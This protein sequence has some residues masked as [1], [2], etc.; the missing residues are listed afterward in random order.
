M[1]TKDTDIQ[2]LLDTAFKTLD[3]IP[4]TRIHS[5]VCAAYTKD[6]T[7]ITSFNVKHYTGAPC[8]EQA[9]LGAACAQGYLPKDLTCLVAVSETRRIVINPC[10]KCRQMLQDICEHIKIV[11]RDSEGKLSVVGIQELL[12]FPYHVRTGEELV[13]PIMSVNEP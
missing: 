4:P 3:K 10:G 5:V 7:I 8:A 11:V 13:L 12:P 2:V 6:N 9:V 1:T